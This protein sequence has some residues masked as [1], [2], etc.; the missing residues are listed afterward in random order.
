MRVCVC[1]CVA[2]GQSTYVGKFGAQRR[3]GGGHAV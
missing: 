1:V 3:E 2:A